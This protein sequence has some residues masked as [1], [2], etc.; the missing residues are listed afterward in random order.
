MKLQIPIMHRNFFKTN[1]I[2]LNF[3]KLIVMIYVILFILHIVNSTYTIVHNVD[4][5]LI[6]KLF[7]YNYT[8]SNII[9]N[10]VRISS[11]ICN[12]LLWYNYLYSNTND[13]III[14]IIVQI[15]FC[16]NIQIRITT[17]IFVHLYK[18]I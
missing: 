12:S 13:N 15:L 6:Q 16:N 4:I 10:F 5:V 17:Q 1:H 3:L 8:Y 9:N 18:Y 7:L 2:I 14:I 11:F